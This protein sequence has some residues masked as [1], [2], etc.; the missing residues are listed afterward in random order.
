MQASHPALVSGASH[1]EDDD[2]LAPLCE[3]DTRIRLADLAARE[4]YLATI[5]AA[6]LADPPDALTPLALRYH[7]AELAAV[8]AEMTFRN[9]AQATEAVSHEEHAA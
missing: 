2:R 5:L 6:L 9:P 8:R 7:R 3:S 1:G 4:T